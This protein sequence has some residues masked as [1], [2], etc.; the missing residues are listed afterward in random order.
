MRLSPSPL[1]SMRSEPNPLRF[2]TVTGGPPVSC[3]VSLTLRRSPLPTGSHATGRVH[4]AWEPVGS[5]E[6]RNVRLT[7]QETGGPPVTVPKRKGFGSL[8]IESS[9]DGDS[10]VDFR[11]DGVRCWLNVSL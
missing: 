10:R 2:G 8:L 3:Q 6:R 4:V 5:G 7:W 9:G 1:D 11:S